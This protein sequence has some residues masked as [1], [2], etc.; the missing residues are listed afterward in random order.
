MNKWKTG[1]LLSYVCIAS[2]SATLI[3]PAFPQIESDYHLAYGQLEWIV[4]I[5]LLGYVLGQLIYAPLA[6]RFGR[7]AAL[8]SGLVLNLMGVLLC[9]IST[10]TL[11]YGLLLGGR[12]ISALGAAAGLSCTF[13]LL[14]ELLGEKEAK[15]AMSFTIVS[16]TLGIGLAVTLG[17]VITEYSH[18][19]NCF[20]LLGLHGVV[21][22]LSTWQFPE[23]LKQSVKLRPL[24]II[25]G[26]YSALK[27]SKLLVYSL[28]IGFASSVGY[29]YSVAAP[30]YTQTM[31]GMTPDRYGF[32]NLI[33][34]L[35]MLSSGFLSAAILKRWEPSTALKIGFIGLVP[36]LGSLVFISYSQ[37]PTALW[38]FMTTMLLYLF[39]GL[40]FPA[41]SFFA[42]NAIADKASASSTMS[43]INM[44][45]AM[46]VVIVMGYLPFQTITAFAATL[47]G[48]FI[49]VLALI[50]YA[51]NHISA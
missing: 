1:L 14:N 11:Q 8:R 34:M 43:F 19:Q 51:K 3:T 39:S 26:Y 9:I 33:N 45:S 17:G 30:L 21:M 20:L 44:G 13:I 38:F 2:V 12:F 35:G 27:N 16:F 5:F 46:M 48:F 41:A 25:S 15:H 23:T 7:L 28:V 37:Q 6:N 32:W 40:L 18:W 42:S 36:C 47:L 50:Y 49:V 29:C 10:H 24:L 31:L 4:S 22:L